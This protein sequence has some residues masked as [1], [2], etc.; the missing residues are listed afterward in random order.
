MNPFRTVW[1]ITK[2]SVNDFVEDDAMTLGA[3]LAFYT[4][5][6][7]APLV[8]LMV[9]ASSFISPDLR[10]Q[11][12]AHIQELAGPEAGAAVGS[13]IAAAQEQ[14][15]LRTLAGLLGLATLLFSATGILG[16]LQYALNR[17]WGVKA[18]P[19][20]GWLGYVR[21]R[22]LSLG[23]LA[24][25]F[26]L[27]LVSLGV[28]ATLSAV[29][30]DV[31]TVWPLMSFLIS[32]G[33]FV[34]LFAAIFRYLPDVEIAWRDTWVGALITALLFDLG[35][36]AI[37]LYI[38][39]S[40]VGSAYGAAGSLVVLLVWVYYS[41]LV[42]FFGAEVTQAVSCRFGSPIVPDAHAVWI[43]NESQEVRQTVP[44]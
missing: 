30:G 22:V 44:G 10:V 14:R 5:L 25:I 41:S 1:D 21:K 17:I 18:K 36:T 34:V 40:S 6:S 24:G 2:K 9:T 3:A 15:Q 4:A 28:D 35:K 13:I 8:V 20:Q 43:D 39:N 23:M 19:G 16:Q 29:L 7:L 26:F 38:G 11:L 37:G 32:L 33:V 42:F 12:T 27:L 31:E